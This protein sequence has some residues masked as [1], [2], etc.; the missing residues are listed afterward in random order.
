M[1]EKLWFTG[2]F[3]FNKLIVLVGFNLTSLALAESPLLVKAQNAGFT[4][5]EYQQSF[6][7]Q[8]F[9]DR[10]VIQRSFGESVNTSETRKIE[11]NGDVAQLI[12][13]S[14]QE[15]F[16]SAPTLCDAP[17]VRVIA[18]NESAGVEF[19]L[20]GHSTCSQDGARN[21]EASTVLK[22]LVNALCGEM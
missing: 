21:G 16:E 8:I 15:N 5:P 6:E 7:C 12:R 9:A 3:M 22:N 1:L 10:V 18:S 19:L 17:A 4:R 13:K 20:Y 14:S 11:L 2:V